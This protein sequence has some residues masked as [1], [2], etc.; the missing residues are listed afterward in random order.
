MR[1][2]RE[3]C[4]NAKQCQIKWY[5]NAEQNKALQKNENHNGGKLYEDVLN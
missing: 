1:Q 2:N 3:S 4:N 5:N